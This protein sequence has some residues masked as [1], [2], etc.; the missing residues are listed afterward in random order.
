MVNYPDVMKHCQAEI[1]DVLGQRAASMKDKAALPYVEAT[2]MELQRI[3]LIVPFGVV[4]PTF[5]LV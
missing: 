5:L 4:D 2:L 1:D 3:S